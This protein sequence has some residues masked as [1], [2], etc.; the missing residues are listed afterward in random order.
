MRARLAYLC[1]RRG[2]IV[3]SIVA[4]IAISWMEVSQYIKS[5]SDETGAVRELE[6]LLHIKH[7]P[8]IRMTSIILAGLLVCWAVGLFWFDRREPSVRQDWSLWR[9]RWF[10][11]LS[12]GWR[13]VVGICLNAIVATS[14]FFAGWFVFDAL[15]GAITDASTTRLVFGCLLPLPVLHVALLLYSWIKQGFSNPND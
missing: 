15:R 2:V 1:F 8:T 5:E 10:L 9:P 7:E 13:R 12:L 3:A 14:L 4:L 6:T 11:Q